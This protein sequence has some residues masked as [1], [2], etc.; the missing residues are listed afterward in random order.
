MI[1]KVEG[2]I[3]LS[4]ASAIIQGVGINDPMD[5]GLA[6]ALQTRYPAMRKDFHRWCHQHNTKPGEAWLWTGSNN[7]HIINLITQDTVD[8]HE[9]RLGKA[10]LGNVKHA[11]DALV[12]IIV[13]ERL[14]SIAIPRL[15]TGSGDL[16]WDDV[17]PLIE[18]SLGHLDIPVY[19]YT[20]YHADQKAEEPEPEI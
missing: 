12:K 2:D 7:N 13:K 14:T 10:T 5:K 16:D 19:V 3:L 11:L 8:S 18:N 1:Y 15:A 6:L 9:Y 20:S 17:W 4:K